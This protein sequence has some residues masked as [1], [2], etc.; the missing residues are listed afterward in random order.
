MGLFDRLRGKK[1]AYT[2]EEQTARPGPIVGFVLLD[3]L[4][5]SFDAFGHHLKEDWALDPGDLSNPESLVFEI[6]GMKVVCG[7]MPAAVP[8]REVEE[9]CKYNF[10]WREAEEVVSQHKAHIIV[11]VL[12]Y[13]DAIEGN[14]LFAKITSSLLKTRQALA[15]YSTPMVMEASQYVDLALALKEDEL[16]VLLWVFIGMYQGEHG[17]GSYT[18]G[19]QSF[20]KDEL[21]VVNSAQAPGDVF[22][23]MSII[24]SYVI[25][26]DV[27]L[28]DGETLG[29]SAEQ[30]LS[31]TRS[32]GVAAQ[33]ESI[34]I[35]Y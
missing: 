24:V 1:E 34:K 5:Y 22:E 19:L 4:D 10:L 7:Y 29:F 17:V 31:L 21:E 16:P 6:D 2:D 26:N 27:T 3:S 25:E 8:N 28:R 23:F 18:A 30:K 33:G 9:N 11:S 12:G 14:K 13:E 35:G 32:A 20:G 15:F